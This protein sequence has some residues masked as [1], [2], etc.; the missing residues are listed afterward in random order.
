[1]K[2]DP[3]TFF[4]ALWMNHEGPFAVHVSIDGPLGRGE[5]DCQVQA[6]YDLRPAPWLLALYVMP[7]L[8]VAVLWG[9]LLLKRRR[10]GALRIHPDSNRGVGS[11]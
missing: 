11:L 3:S 2:N 1:V 10:T 9:K 8:A 5:L 7:F 6:T 4:A